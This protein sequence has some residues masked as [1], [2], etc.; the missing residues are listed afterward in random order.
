[1]QNTFHKRWLGWVPK[2][3][4]TSNLEKVSLLHLNGSLTER[5]CAHEYKYLDV[6]VS[7]GPHG[8]ALWTLPPPHIEYGARGRA[9]DRKQ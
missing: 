4:I 5:P 6:E 9:R 8:M 3:A 7:A 2:R 1:M